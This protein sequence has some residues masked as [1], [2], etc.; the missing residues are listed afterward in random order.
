[1]FGI[2]LFLTYY[3]QT[4]LKFTPINTG[5]ALLPMVATLV[6][7]AQLGTNIFVPRFGPKILVPIGMGLGA[8][9][10]LILTGLEV[11]SSYAG[12][13]LPALLVLGAAMGTIMPASMQ[14]ATLGVDRQFAGV[15]SAMTN[16][17][18][19]VGG[20]ISTALLNTLAASAATSYV[21][22]HLPPTPAIAAAAAVHGYTTAFALCAAFFAGGLVIAALLFRGRGQGLSLAHAAAPTSTSVTAPEPVVAH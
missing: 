20:S 6:L 13:V 11:D 9:G 8:I 16:T 12:H 14:S 5:L 15:A 4:T 2:F 3:I 19:Q 21:S 17:S 1:M 18:Q 7:F 22:S 10:M